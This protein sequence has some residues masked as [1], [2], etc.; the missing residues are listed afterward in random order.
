MKKYSLE[1]IKLAIMNHDF[2]GE[3]SEEST[4]KRTSVWRSVKTF[5]LDH[6][7][8]FENLYNLSN[9]NKIEKID[10]KS[11]EKGK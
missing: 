11:K 7:K 10:N 1:E 5:L 4:K 3:R 2:C 8:E 9:S 6:E